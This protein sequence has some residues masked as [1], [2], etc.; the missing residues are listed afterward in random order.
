M[1]P[2]EPFPDTNE[3]RRWS[4]LKK[5]M[6]KQQFSCL[7]PKQLH[8]AVVLPSSFKWKR[9]M[10]SPWAGMCD[11]IHPMWVQM[12]HAGST[13]E[14]VTSCGIYL[15][16]SSQTSCIYH[17]HSRFLKNHHLCSVLSKGL[18][19]NMIM[20]TS[21][22]SFTLTWGPQS[23]TTGV[24]HCNLAELFSNSVGYSE[25]LNTYFISYYPESAEFC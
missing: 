9:H 17:Q 6:W 13:R 25:L 15:T 20:R 2:P 21:Y 16:N 4:G 22:G 3:Q 12:G 1:L 11:G 18:T 10:C 7:S 8:T 5:Q 24:V 14:G 19:E 23:R